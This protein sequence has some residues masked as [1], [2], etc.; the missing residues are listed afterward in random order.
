[1]TEGICSQSL[2]WLCLVDP[3]HIANKTHLSFWFDNCS[4][5]SFHI[6]VFYSKIPRPLSLA[7]WDSVFVWALLH[8]ILWLL[9]FRKRILGKMSFFSL[10][11]FFY[12]RFG[13]V[14]LMPQPAP[15]QTSKFSLSAFQLISVLIL[16]PGGLDPGMRWGLMLCSP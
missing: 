9:V 2:Y 8:W 16:D 15:S 13:W 7:E 14:N 12:K 4:F 1:M 6:C 3:F 5:Y 10:L 11:L